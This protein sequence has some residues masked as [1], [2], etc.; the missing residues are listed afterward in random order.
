MCHTD[1][2]I[3]Y[4]YTV[5][6][7]NG[8]TMATLVTH[9]PLHIAMDTMRNY[10][11]GGEHDLRWCAV[12]CETTQAKAIYACVTGEAVRICGDD[13]VAREY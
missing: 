6:A 2:S 7:N 8:N 10:C 3:D 1:K 12:T 11:T 9:A 5:I 4:A 13:F